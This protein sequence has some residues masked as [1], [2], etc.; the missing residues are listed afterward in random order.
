[1]R[2]ILFFMLVGLQLSA[3][4]L[5][6][7]KGM[8]IDSIP[9][10]DTISESFSVYLPKSFANGEKPLPVLFIFDSQ[11]SG[12][13][14]AQLFKP[15]AEE[16]GYILASSNDIKPGNTF[17]ENVHVATRLINSVAARIP[18]DFN[19]VSVAGFSEGAR[20]ANAMPLIFSNIHGVIAVGGHLLNADY[21]NKNNKFVFVGISGDEEYSSY[22]MQTNANLLENRGFPAQVY[23]VDGGDTW[24]NPEVLSSGLAALTLEAMKAGKRPVDRQL[25]Q[26]LYQQDLARVDKMLS[27][28][29]YFKAYHFLEQLQTKYE[30]LLN[31]AELK[32][33]QRQVRRSRNFVEQ[34]REMERVQEKE[35]RLIDDFIYYFNEDVNT[36]NFENLGWWNYQK[37]QLQELAKGENEPEADMA[38]RL[39]GML[40]EMA[41][42][43]RAEL[44]AAPTA[45][46]ESR[47]F[48]NMIQTIFDPGNFEAYK[49]VISL[50][51]RDGDYGTALFYLEEMLKHGYS[52]MDELYE[53]EGT[54]ALRMTH[55]YNWLIKK[56][57]GSSR[58]Y[59]VPA[60]E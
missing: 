34:R 27:N 2:M 21:L 51:A 40:N 42:T 33:R 26:T 15:A 20:V 19:S 30:G 37:L 35:S 59:D 60:D 11:G 49:K 22:G 36:A 46:L 47:L 14:A 25:I 8:V 1:M 23:F 56:Y 29:E 39:L 53:L 5:T 7:R 13:K 10:N 32:E 38:N 4:E 9:V 48:A 28:G 44:A 41:R 55:D 52:N 57:L 24:P 6:L 54:L 43:K 12:K 17:E 18:V 45:S 3:Q 50:S 58:Y 31:T 16:Q